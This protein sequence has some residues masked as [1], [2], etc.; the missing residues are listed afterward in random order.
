[1][2]EEYYTSKEA[3]RITRLSMSTLR[4]R[5]TEGEIPRYK[6]S[7]KILIPASYIIGSN[8]QI[9]EMDIKNKE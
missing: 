7:S 2:Q 8:A 9:N 6:Y 5:V 4:R 1:M 3:A